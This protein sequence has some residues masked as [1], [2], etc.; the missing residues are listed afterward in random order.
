[1]SYRKLEDKTGISKTTLH[2]Y[3]HGY[4]KHLPLNRLFILSHALETNVAY[5]MGRDNK[6][7]EK[8]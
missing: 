2:G 1:M 3:E 6:S 4:I 5:L 7:E 8:M